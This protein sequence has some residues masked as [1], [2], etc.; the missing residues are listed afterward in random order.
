MLKI[1]FAVIQ[2]VAG[3][4]VVVGLLVVDLRDTVDLPLPFS[5]TRNVTFESNSRP[6][7]SRTA[8][9]ENGY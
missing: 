9:I 7:R 2:E 4:L 5:P 6:S 1:A 3:E 8:G